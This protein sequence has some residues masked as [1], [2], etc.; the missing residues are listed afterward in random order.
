MKNREGCTEQ[1]AEMLSR[2]V[3]QAR[4]LGAYCRV[5]RAHLQAHEAAL[6]RQ[7]TTLAGQDEAARRLMIFQRQSAA[8]RMKWICGCER[9]QERLFRRMERAR[10]KRSGWSFRRA[11]RAQK[12]L[13]R[14]CAQL[15]DRQK[16]QK[17][18]RRTMQ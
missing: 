6:E 12:Q 15:F 3:E 13:E 17:Q 7:K 14:L 18:S 5:Q 10:S 9:Q 1:T 8:R 11:K 16:R 2:C 4:R